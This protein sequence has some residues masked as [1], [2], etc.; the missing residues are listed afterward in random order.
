MAE[1]FGRE[2]HSTIVCQIRFFFVKAFIQKDE[3]FG[4]GMNK[5]VTNL[6]P[7]ISE[8]NGK[9]EKGRGIAFV[10]SKLKGI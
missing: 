5:I 8:G 2:Y 1:A 6:L 9:M 3:Q 4:H 10:S 7:H